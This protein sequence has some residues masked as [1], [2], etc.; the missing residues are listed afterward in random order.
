MSC[1]KCGNKLKKNTTRCSKCGTNND[2]LTPNAPI[3]SNGILSDSLKAMLQSFSIEPEKAILTAAHSKG[4][5]WVILGGMH[6]I[7]SAIHYRILVEN[8]LMGSILGIMLMEGQ[9]PINSDLSQMLS[10]FKLAGF[11]SSIIYMLI[12]VF[13]VSFLY[14]KFKIDF[15]FIKVINIVTASTIVSSAAMAIAIALSFLSISGAINL[16]IAGIIAHIVLLYRGIQKSAEFSSSPFWTYFAILVINMVTCS[17][18]LPRIMQ[19][20]FV[21]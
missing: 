10:R 13:G 14:S 18:I 19:A 11:V 16:F 17:V 20:P 4:H 9:T 21:Q 3:H 6:S 2:E 12:L 8:N 15:R 5:I 7:L 1:I